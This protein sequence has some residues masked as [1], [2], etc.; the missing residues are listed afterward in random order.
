MVGVGGGVLSENLVDGV[1]GGV[2]LENIMDGVE[3]GYYQRT[4]W[5][6]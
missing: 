1:E 4:S 5:M 6:E 3:V 2:L